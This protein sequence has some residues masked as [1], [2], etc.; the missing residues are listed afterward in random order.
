M[1]QKIG[2]LDREYA[3][4]G[5]K[6]IEELDRQI[7]LAERAYFGTIDTPHVERKQTPEYWLAYRQAVVNVRRVLWPTK[8]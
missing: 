2:A 7:T 5:R 1:A 6:T 8:R 4:L 3:E